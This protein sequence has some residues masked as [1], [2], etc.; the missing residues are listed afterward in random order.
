[1]QGEYQEVAVRE[2]LHWKHP[3]KVFTYQHL[4][5]GQDVSL[6]LPLVLDHVSVPEVISLGDFYVQDI[7]VPW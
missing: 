5:P 3:D 4:L 7:F 1:M 6:E 2:G